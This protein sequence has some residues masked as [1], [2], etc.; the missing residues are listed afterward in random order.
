MERTVSLYDLSQ[1]VVAQQHP[2]LFWLSTGMFVGVIEKHLPEDSTHYAAIRLLAR[3][4]MDNSGD[5]NI[6]KARD[7]VNAIGMLAKDLPP[8]KR[9]AAAEVQH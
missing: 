1:L 7:F 4:L 9:K 5:H 3:Y 8:L 6:T 2:D